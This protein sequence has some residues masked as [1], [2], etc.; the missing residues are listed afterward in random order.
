MA[1]ELLTAAELTT[2]ADTL[3]DI[4]GGL[5]DGS[6]SVTYKRRTG[7]TRDATAAN[8]NVYTYDDQ[9]LTM[10]FPSLGS[11]REGENRVGESPKMAGPLE[12]IISRQAFEAAYASGVRPAT[13]DKIT[14]GS[15]TYEVLGWSICPLD[16]LLSI[17]LKRV[18]T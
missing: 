17:S 1:N 16:A 18:G 12:A 2:L 3:D 9:A 8:A 14:V 13:T 11:V 15:V 7:R 10:T 6:R 4:V 5:G